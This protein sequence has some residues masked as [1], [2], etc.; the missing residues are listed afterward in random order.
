MGSEITR[1]GGLTVHRWET[2]FTRIVGKAPAHVLAK[3]NAQLAMMLKCGSTSEM[4]RILQSEDLGEYGVVLQIAGQAL[5]NEDP[6]VAFDTMMRIIERIGGKP[7]L[8]TDT[9]AAAP[10]RINTVNINVHTD[11]EKRTLQDAFEVLRKQRD[12]MATEAEVVNE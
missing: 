4:R 7:V 1:R 12:S 10:A 6:K 11:E 2:E 9:D 3:F 5:L 8:S